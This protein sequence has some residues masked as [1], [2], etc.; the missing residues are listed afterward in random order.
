MRDRVLD[1]L[2]LIQLMVDVGKR[3]FYKL[4]K[5]REEEE[6]MYGKMKK[7]GVRQVIF[8]WDTFRSGGEKKVKCVWSVYKNL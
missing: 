4:E 6:E 3:F 7:K 1:A 5:K 2:P 8:I